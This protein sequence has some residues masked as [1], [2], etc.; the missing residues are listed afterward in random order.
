MKPKHGSICVTKTKDNSW[1][2]ACM[3]SDNQEKLSLLLGDI[4]ELVQANE[5]VHHHSDILILG[6]LQSVSQEILVPGKISLVVLMTPTSKSMW[7]ILGPSLGILSLRDP[8]GHQHQAISLFLLVQEEEECSWKHQI[9]I[10][11]LD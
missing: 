6:S 4:G 9:L 5:D 1:V 8:M 3:L 11:G 7:K 2:R 10:L